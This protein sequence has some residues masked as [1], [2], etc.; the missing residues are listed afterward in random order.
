[1]TNLLDGNN[2]FKDP[3]YKKKILLF[4]IETS[5]LISYTWGIW[6]QN[7][8]EVKEEWYML[9]FAY[10]WLGEK[11]THIVAL[12]DFEG[13][14]GNKKND[15]FLVRKL[16]ELFC[17]AEIIVAHNGDQFDIKKANARFLQ[18]GLEPP[19]PYKTIDTL[20]IAR[21]YF[22]FDSNKLDHLGQYL[23]VGRKLAHTGKHLWFGC[24]EGDLK[25]WELMKRYNIQDV[26]LLEK[27]YLKLRAWATN[28][29]NLN[30]VYGTFLHCPTC[31][32]EHLEKRGYRTTQVSVFQRY[33]CQNC[34]H[35]CQGESVKS[36][37]PIK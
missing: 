29:P 3:P 13:Y 14:E 21:R 33:Q 11:Q 17:E 25:S 7:V 24:M 19:T 26:V 20:K 32:S 28:S 15:E 34:G 35:W 30:M 6:E 22:K 9:C 12:P 31:G 36:P 1:M 27:V 37:K 10:K 18:L 4:D 8:I 23:K 16:W 5:P 2:L